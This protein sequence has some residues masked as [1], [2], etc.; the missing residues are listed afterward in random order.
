MSRLAILTLLLFSTL[1]GEEWEECR[2]GPFEVWTN[3]G[4]KDA[5][6]L[7]VRLEQVR[8]MVGV[9]LGKNDPV[10]LW[11]IRVLLRKGKNTPG[12]DWRLGRDAW[13]STLPE[14]AT[15]SAD[16]IKQVARM[17]MDSNA[18]RLPAY[19]EQGLLTFLSTLDAKGPRITLG[20]PPVLTQRNLDW[21]RVHYLATN[22]EYTTRFRV[23]MNNLQQGADEDVAYRN[24]IGRTK[25]E[26]EKDI[27]A[28]LAAGQFASVEVSGRA[29]SE[30]DFYTRPIEPPRAAAA[31]EDASGAFQLEKQTLDWLKKATTEGT[32]SAR[33]YLELGKR[34]T[35]PKPKQ[36]AFVEAAKKNPRWAQP[37]IEL[38]NMEKTP[39]R[40]AFYLKTAA[41]LDPRNS[42]LWQRLAETQLDAKQFPEASR[43]WFNA[44]LAAAS[45]AE[46]D[47]IRVARREFEAERARREDAEKQRIADERQRELDRLREEAMNKVRE[48]EARANKGQTPLPSGAKVEEWWDDKTPSQ[49]ISGLLQKV[50]CMGKLARVWILPPGGKPVPLL[51]RDAGQVVIVGGGETAFGC[52][53]QNP[54]RNATVEYKPRPDTK[55]NSQGDVSLIEFR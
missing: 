11:T 9:Y 32:T 39:E 22:P 26:L 7:L 50:D 43:S 20:A 48:A 45:V 6:V 19:W 51:I 2:S 21:A 54:P 5:R 25:G 38:A 37:Y 35:E 1:H 13:I 29:M 46:R 12:T 10:S 36:D 24:S 30:R 8:H 34:L 31:L 49:K 41:G 33:I 18:R 52:G 47:A 14:D 15:P 23:L 44:E 3:A 4:E 55:Q 17:L 42:K 16:W 40:I 28:Y 27:A 53:P